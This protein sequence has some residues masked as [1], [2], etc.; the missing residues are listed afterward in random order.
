MGLL[1]NVLAAK[2]AAEAA[3]ASHVQN[4]G[5]LSESQH[6]E[7]LIAQVKAILAGETPTP[8][9]ESEPKE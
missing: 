7:I 2:A 3:Y 1:E 9:P 6:A 5:S 8:E 4:G